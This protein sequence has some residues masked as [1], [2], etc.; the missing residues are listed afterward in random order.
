MIARRGIT[1]AGSRDAC[2][3]H[4]RAVVRVVA[5]V[6]ELRRRNSGGDFTTPRVLRLHRHL[7]PAPSPS[8]PLTMTVPPL[9]LGR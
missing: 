7:E 2:V 1:A 9:A 6:N 5:L 3:P 4:V 8:I